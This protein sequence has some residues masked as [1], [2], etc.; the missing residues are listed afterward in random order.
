MNEEGNEPSIPG[1]APHSQA[2]ES[3]I[4]LLTEDDMRRQM[5]GRIHRGSIKSVGQPEIT[6]L[7]LMTTRE[8]SGLIHNF[9]SFQTDALVWYVEFHGTFLFAGG[10]P[11]YQ[12][13]NIPHE[14]N[15]FEIIDAQT[16]NC[17]VKGFVTK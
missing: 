4:P 9:I 5:A 14:T 6:Q 11:G 3:P 16:G 13:G 12:G 8:A 2:N 10:P 7:T 15:V 1:K 17:L